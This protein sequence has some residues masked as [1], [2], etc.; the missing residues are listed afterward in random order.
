M[1][2]KVTPEAKE[3]L[4]SY[5]NDATVDLLLDFD[6]GVGPLSPKGAC[7][8]LTVFRLV[9]VKTGEYSKD[10]NAKLA[11]DI[12]VLRY[13]DYSATYMDEEMT[14]VLD[15]QTQALQLKGNQNGVL[16]PNL[17]IVDFR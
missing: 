4:V 3:K 13:K 11:S 8:L 17:A 10:Y 16:A 14:L 15:P 7:A 12:G 6:D 1:Y 9:V 5:L 2:L